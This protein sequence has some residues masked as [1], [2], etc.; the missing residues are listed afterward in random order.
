MP[1][2]ERSHPSGISIP[3]LPGPMRWIAGPLSQQRAR[4]HR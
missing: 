2:H 3:T 4:R 1:T